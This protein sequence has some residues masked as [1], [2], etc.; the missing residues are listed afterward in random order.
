[1]FILLICKL[2]HKILISENSISAYVAHC[3]LERNTDTVTIRLGEKSR[4]F[5]K[6]YRLSA[7]RAKPY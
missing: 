5:E 4:F 2:I 6:N 1:M 3:G 7:R